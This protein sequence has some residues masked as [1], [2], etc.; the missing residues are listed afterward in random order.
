LLTGKTGSRSVERIRENLQSIGL[1]TPSFR[2]PSKIEDKSV[3]CICD[4]A[5][6]P[7]PQVTV[8]KNKKIKA[9]KGV[10]IEQI[11]L[12][13]QQPTMPINFTDLCQ[14][15]KLVGRY[16]NKS[17]EPLNPTKTAN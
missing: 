3:G 13:Q 6:E 5:T 8:I 14:T 9:K 1:E 15:K 17:L 11:K 12:K 7:Q 16:E 10:Q 2:E 4:D